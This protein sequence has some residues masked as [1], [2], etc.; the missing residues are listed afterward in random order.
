VYRRPCCAAHCADR[1]A[2]DAEV[3]ELLVCTPRLQGLNL[4]AVR[5][6]GLDLRDREL[7][8]CR[9]SGA[10]WENVRLDGAILHHAYLDFATLR[11]CSLR[12]VNATLSVFAGASIS[13][14][15]LTQSDLPRNN[16][17]GLTC[18]AT[19]FRSSDLSSCR[20]NG[21]RLQQVDFQD[22]DLY[23]VH[24]ESALMKDVNLRYSNTEEAHFT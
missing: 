6:R 21:A 20:F 5:C 16:F 13:S 9:F 10:V 12:G 8:G 14:S 7:I 24:F 11:D 4:A 3:T 1:A 17:V 19:S 15:R 18:T 2:Y 23:H 22:C